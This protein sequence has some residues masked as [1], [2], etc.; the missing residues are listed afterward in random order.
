MS[1]NFI[2]H[3]KRNKYRS[4]YTTYIFNHTKGICKCL[5]FMN[6]LNSEI[7][8]KYYRSKLNYSYK[9]KY[10]NKYYF[11]TYIHEQAEIDGLN[12]P[13]S[14]SYIYFQITCICPI[15]SDLRLGTIIVRHICMMPVILNF[16]KHY[17][18]IH[19]FVHSLYVQ[20]II[21]PLC[22][23]KTTFDSNVIDIH[24][25]DQNSKRFHSFKLILNFDIIQSI[26]I[27]FMLF[28]IYV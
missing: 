14:D 22:L 3:L 18:T 25:I 15:L 6:E 5:N 8:T 20:N 4:M 10:L 26:K 1:I 16:L 27:F 2:F 12:Q 24:F 21:R 17:S 28:R 19:S 23:K 11:C 13:H 7:R 9:L